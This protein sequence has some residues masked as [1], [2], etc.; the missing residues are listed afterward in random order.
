MAA[1]GLVAYAVTNLGDEYAGDRSTTLQGQPKYLHE[2]A[3]EG[4]DALSKPLAVTASGKNVY[5]TDSARGK[6]AIFTRRGSLTKSFDLLKG[7]QPYPVGVAIDDKDRIYASVEVRGYFHIMV[8]DKDGRFQ[9]RFPGDL[10]GVQNK[11]PLNHPVGLYYRDGKLYVTDVGDH[12]VKIFSTDGRLLKKFGGP[13]TGKGKF[14]F[15]HGIVFDGKRIFVV[16]SN[17]A[18]VQVFDESGRFLYLFKSSEEDPLAIPRG[19]AVDSLGRVHVVDLARQKVF[20]F[21]KEGKPLLS[22]GDGQGSK[23]LSFPNGISIDPERG[24]IYVTD[25]QKNR[26]AVFSE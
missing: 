26:I 13:G 15:P 23:G 25:R 17:N 3:G 12:D 6:I 20:V 5:I 22:Y 19:I 11:R 1:A 9:Y 18:R 21:T 24:L 4:K 8:F 14:Q 7:G 16:D 10:P 2:I